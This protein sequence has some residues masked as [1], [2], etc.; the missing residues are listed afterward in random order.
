[1]NRY[2]PLLLLLSAALRAEGEPARPV[3]DPAAPYQ[4]KKSDAVTYEVDFS[5]VVTAPAQTRLLRVWLP[6]PQTDGG[7]EVTEGDL[8]T[9]PLVVKPVIAEEPVFGN[10]FARFEFARPEGAQM[11]RH[12]F[13]IKVWE[14]RWHIEPAKVVRVEKWPESFHCYLRSEPAVQVDER[15][16]QL[17]KDFV[18]RSQGPARDLDA[19][20]AGVSARMKY[21]HADASLRA[22]AEHALL[23]GRGHC[24]DYHGLCASVG[25]ALGYP[26][27]IIYGIHP[28][29]KSSPSH[30]KL[31]AYLPPYGWVSFDVSET[32]KL[33]ESIRE[34][35][36]IA[37]R[38]RQELIEAATARLQSGFRDN[39]FF[40]QTR[41]TDYELPG[42]PRVPLVRTIFADADGVALPE[43]DPANPKRR[44]FAWMTLHQ[45][46]P[47][48]TVSYPFKDWKTLLRK[49]T[50][51]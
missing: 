35:K 27:R 2:L 46:T 21:D 42:G 33:I 47:D 1:M 9:F 23:K 40:L 5:V 30:C 17:A 3:L 43:A 37:D 20:L 34:D 25:R 7:Q 13:R 8:T 19:V 51:D 45:Y 28:F 16:R 39:T 38:Q 4:A 12:R 22:S 49:S 41:G 6:L 15:F 11:I 29:P 18:P 48:R 44:E 31:E 36:G 26:T 24:S 50:G 32:Q 10:R 14:L